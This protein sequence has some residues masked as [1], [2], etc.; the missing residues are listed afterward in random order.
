MGQPS[1]NQVSFCWFVELMKQG[2]LFFQS[3][4]AFVR[5]TLPKYLEELRIRSRRPTRTVDGCKSSPVNPAQ[6][7]D[8]PEVLVASDGRRFREGQWQVCGAL[9]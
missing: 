4:F 9:L 6:K 3:F 1:R 7:S 5:Y 8:E 2:F